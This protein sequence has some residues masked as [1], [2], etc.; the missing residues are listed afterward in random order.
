MLIQATQ[1]LINCKSEVEWPPGL[2]THLVYVLSLYVKHGWTEG[3]AR[4]GSP[5]YG[6]KIVSCDPC[7][8]FY[9]L[10]SEWT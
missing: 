5:S 1:V 4:E 3:R 6:L 8:A 9:T 10:A 7:F 2:R